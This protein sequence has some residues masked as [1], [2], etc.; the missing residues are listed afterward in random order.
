[1]SESTK[2]EVLGVENGVVWR[3]IITLA[4]IVWKILDFTHFDQFWGQFW[5]PWGQKLGELIFWWVWKYHKLKLYLFIDFASTTKL[6]VT[7]GTLA[8]RTGQ[9]YLQYFPSKWLIIFLILLAAIK[10]SLGAYILSSKYNV[11][12]FNIGYESDSPRVTYGTHFRGQPTYLR[13]NI[14]F[15]VDS[16]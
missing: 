10:A 16:V 6:G 9:Q 2:T 5:H 7:Y 1:M 8:S 3:K 11:F 12:N 13:K 15:T 4:Q 14:F